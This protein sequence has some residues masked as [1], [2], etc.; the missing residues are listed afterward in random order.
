M[1]L[2]DDAQSGASPPASPRQSSGWRRSSPNARMRSSARSSRRISRRSG[3]SLRRIP[4]IDPIDNPLSPISRTSRNRW[5]QAV[6]FSAS[7]DV[8]GSM[9]EHMKDLAKTVSTCLLY[10]F[11]HP[12]GIAT[13]EIVFIR[14]NRSGRRGGRGRP[15]SVA[16]A[17]R[18]EQLV[19]ER[20]RSDAAD[21]HDAIYRPGRLEYPMR[22]R[23]SDGD[24]SYGRRR[25]HRASAS[26]R[27]SL[28]V[29]QYFA[30]LEVWRSP[31]AGRCRTSGPVDALPASAL[32]TVRFFR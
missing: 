30:Y 17:T 11:S 19:I 1:R 8:S 3:P 6:M 23:P 22:R 9:S 25:G 20:A 2:A 27:R 26:G 13:S 4:Y 5:R 14:H 32:P 31:G 29:S 15:S 21:H 12:G 28:P 7:M 18:R 24:N 10:I 16:Q